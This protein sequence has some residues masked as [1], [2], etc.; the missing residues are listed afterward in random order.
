MARCMSRD[1]SGI[2]RGMQLPVAKWM[3]CSRD[4][5]FHPN[6]FKR[7]GADLIFVNCTSFTLIPTK[8]LALAAMSPQIQKPAP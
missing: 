2:S 1:S 7:L 4:F 6:T 3:Q 5:Y 8:T